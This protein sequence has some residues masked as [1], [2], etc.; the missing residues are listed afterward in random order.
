MPLVVQRASDV[1]ASPTTIVITA[2]GAIAL[3]TLPYAGTAKQVVA[4][5]TDGSVEVIDLE[6]T[7]SLTVT[8]NTTKLTCGGN[9]L[10]NALKIATGQDGTELGDVSAAVNLTSGDYVDPGATVV[11]VTGA[12]Q[13]IGTGLTATNVTL[14]LTAFQKMDVNEDHPSGTYQ[15]TLT[16]AYT[17]TP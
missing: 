5:G 11:A 15:L 2:P 6:G 8:G 9:T 13:T 10:T 16:Y 1:S 12:A 14:K 7:Y 4:H 3:G 17:V